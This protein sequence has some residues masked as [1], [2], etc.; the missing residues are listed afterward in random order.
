MNAPVTSSSSAR[1]CAR[2]GYES[3]WAGNLKTAHRYR[4]HL[5]HELLA[6]DSETSDEETTRR[7]AQLDNTAVGDSG[8][9]Q[10]TVLT[11]LTR[12]VRSDERESAEDDVDDVSR[13]VE[14][15]ELP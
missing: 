12:S 13:N 15:D 3:A 8:L 6:H 14:L 1:S 5:S 9:R 10:I 7:A 4:S 2:S 11:R